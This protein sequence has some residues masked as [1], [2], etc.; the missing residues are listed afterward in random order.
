MKPASYDIEQYQGDTLVLP[1]RVRALN[2]NG[3]LGAYYNLTGWTA[4]AQVRLKSG[5]TI[6][7]SLTVVIDSDQTANPGLLVISATAAQTGAW[8]TAAMIWDL[9]LTDTSGQVRTVVAGAVRVT[10]DV[11]ELP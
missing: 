2:S 5:N 9:Q 7:Q 10:E 3:S 6:V 8:T 1:M 4:A 11:T